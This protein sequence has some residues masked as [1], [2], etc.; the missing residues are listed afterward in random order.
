MPEPR[1]RGD[2]L[3]YVRQGIRSRPHFLAYRVKDLPASLAAPRP[4]RSGPAAAD[5]DGANAGRPA[6][7][8]ALGRPDDLRGLSAVILH[9]GRPKTE[10]DQMSKSDLRIRVIPAIADIPRAAWDACANPGEPGSRS[11]AKRLGRLE[12]CP[13][14]ESASQSSAPLAPQLLES[15]SELARPASRHLEPRSRRVESPSEDVK[16]PSQGRPDSDTEQTPYNPFISHHFL[17]A[18]EASGSAAARTGWQPQ[19]LVAES[20]DGAV[21]RRRALLSEIAFARRIRVRR[22]LGRGL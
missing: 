2:Q 18:L 22:R 16:S 13:E 17:S 7:R 6:A 8:G 11:A 12:K 19:H 20:Q 1:P 14:S 5:L 4:L 9:G 3:A 15:A 21:R 10:N